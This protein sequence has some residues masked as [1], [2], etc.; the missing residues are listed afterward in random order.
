M[1]HSSIAATRR[2]CRRSSG[3]GTQASAIPGTAMRTVFGAPIRRNPS[4]DTSTP[5]RTSAPN[6]PP[7]GR[8]P[9]PARS[10]AG[11]DRVAGSPASPVLARRRAPTRRAR[12]AARPRRSAAP[13]WRSAG[14]CG[15]RRAVVARQADHRRDQLGE[16]PAVVVGRVVVDE[17]RHGRQQRMGAAGM[18][19]PSL[20]GEVGGHLHEAGPLAGAAVL[21]PRQDR[22]EVGRIG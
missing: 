22:H 17:P 15:R 19:A 20:A 14:R 9:A 21:A 18:V 1:A 13:P 8:W 10:P 7:A 16:M 4:T 12:S 3:S 11:D 5:S 2:S 6:G